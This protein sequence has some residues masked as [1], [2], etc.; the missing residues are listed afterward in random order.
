MKYNYSLMGKKSALVR[1][2]KVHSKV[3][4]CNKISKEK[5]AIIA[6]LSGDGYIKFRQKGFHYE[7]V[8]FMDDLTVAKRI[9]G[10]FLKEYHVSPKIRRIP[11]TVKK[12][13]G[14]YRVEIKNKV[15][16]LDLLS[17]GK[18]GK[19]EWNFPSKISDSMKKEWI[20]CFFDCEAHV[21]K[22]RPQIQV[23]SVNSKGLR[24]IGDHLIRLNINNKVYGPYDNGLNHNPYFMLSI[25]RAEDILKY[26]KLIGFY[27]KEKQIVLQSF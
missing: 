10:L 21:H 8:F 14:Y 17:F 6:Y 2:D 12:G 5:V 7:I 24:A 22:N 27:H 13:K 15:A 11:T 23:K 3:R 25:Y 19:L 16:C 1:W 20:K 26:N 4:L 9:V 18:Y